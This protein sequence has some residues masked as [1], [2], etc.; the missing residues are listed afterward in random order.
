MTSP[1]L[2]SPSHSL[3]GDFLEQIYKQFRRMWKKPTNNVEYAFKLKENIQ[4]ERNYKK[5]HNM[6]LMY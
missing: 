2:P 3:G 5:N 4:Q 6:A 1:S